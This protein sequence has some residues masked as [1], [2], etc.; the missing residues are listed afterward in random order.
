[1][2]QD[3]A[4]VRRASGRG[5]L[6]VALERRAHAERAA[7]PALFRGDLEGLRLGD[8]KEH[9]HVLGADA[10]DRLGFFEELVDLVLP[11]LDKDARLRPQARD[12]LLDRFDQVLD[13]LVFADLHPH[14]HGR[15]AIR[16]AAL[17]D[18]C[19]RDGRHPLLGRCHELQLRRQEGVERDR[20]STTTVLR[21]RALDHRLEKTNEQV[22]DP[23]I[24]PLA[25]ILQSLH[26]NLLVAPPVGLF[27][28]DVRLRALHL[29]AI[30][31]E[32]VQDVLD[33]F[34]RI[35][36]AVAAEL[37]RKLADLPLEVPRRHLRGVL[38]PHERQQRRE[39]LRQLPLGLVSGP[40]EGSSVLV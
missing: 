30:L 40:I 17:P 3:G 22:V 33:Q 14:L 29:V 31:F 24:A 12:L 39:A 10:V 1:M 9:E 15:L 28:L 21:F 5:V 2:V 38:P 32:A 18:V 36:L 7:A 27:D 19:E 35:L 16:R 6:G 11:D 20:S 23:G 37:L 4:A 26:G 34:H 13:A 8:L 25:V